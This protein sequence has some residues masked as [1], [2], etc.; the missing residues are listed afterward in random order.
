[1]KRIAAGV[2]RALAQLLL[3]AQE[4]VVLGGPVG[5]RERARLDLAG[6]AADG[7]VGDGRVL[8]LARTMRDHRGVTRA[9]RHLDRL[10]GLRERADLVDLDEDGVGNAALDALG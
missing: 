8:G 3:D 4:L 7:D 1:M 6:I 9:P 5:A 2:L 10:E